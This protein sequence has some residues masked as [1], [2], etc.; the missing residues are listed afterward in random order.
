MSGVVEL[1]HTDMR[2]RLIIINVIIVSLINI[3]YECTFSRQRDASALMSQRKLTPTACRQSS[4]SGVSGS[5]DSLLTGRAQTALT[6]STLN[7]QRSH[8]NRNSTSING[9]VSTSSD[10]SD[11]SGRDQ[12]LPQSA[13]RTSGRRQTSVIKTTQKHRV[14]KATDNVTDAVKPRPAQS[15]KIQSVPPDKKTALMLSSKSITTKHAASRELQMAVTP[16]PTSRNNE[17]TIACHKPKVSSNINVS[18]MRHDA[19]KDKNTGRTSRL[20]VK[21]HTTA[22]HNT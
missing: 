22:T 13:A 17:V 2:S 12:S 5:E 11:T 18:T 4:L 6:T 1:T 21:P 14:H 7:R 20:A 3:L 15:N 19:A 9:C 8:L 10:Q 16:Q